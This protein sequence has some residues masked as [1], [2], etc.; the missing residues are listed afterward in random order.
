MD[1][2]LDISQTLV[3]G[4]A[5]ESACASVNDFLSLRTFLVRSGRSKKCHS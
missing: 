3:P 2:W 4:A 5:F 1:Q